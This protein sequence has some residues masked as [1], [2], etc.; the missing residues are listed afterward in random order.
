[1]DEENFLQK[2]AYP[3]KNKWDTHTIQSSPIKGIIQQ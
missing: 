2:C 1:M 3:N